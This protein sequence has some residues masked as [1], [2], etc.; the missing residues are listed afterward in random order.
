MLTNPLLI[1]NSLT[2]VLFSFFVFAL[3]SFIRVPGELLEKV[4][5]GHTD[6][7]VGAHEEGCNRAIVCVQLVQ[8]LIHPPTCC[9]V[10]GMANSVPEQRCINPH[11]PPSLEWAALYQN[12]DSVLEYSIPPHAAMFGEWPG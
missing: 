3:A 8:E 11:V 12:K 1:H 9:H 10:C 2:D 4:W 7:A 5:A 6:H